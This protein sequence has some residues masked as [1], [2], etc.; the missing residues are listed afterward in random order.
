[1]WKCTAH[2]SLCH[3]P[4]LVVLECV[5]K[6]KKQVEQ[7]RGSNPVNCH[8][9]RSLPSVPAS[10]FPS[11]A[12]ALTFSRLW[13]GCKSHTLSSHVAFGH[14][15]Y[16][17]NK[18]QTTTDSPYFNLTHRKQVIF[19]IFLCLYKLDVSCHWNHESNVLK[20]RTQNFSGCTLNP[21]KAF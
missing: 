20:K 16:P 5:K 15:V 17:D 2:C 9:S 21:F 14:G 19:L 8:N 10:R 1:M 12:Q 11:W 7:A 3:T 18:N 13:P 6:K 4:G